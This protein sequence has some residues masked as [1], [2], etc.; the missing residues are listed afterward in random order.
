MSVIGSNILAGASG[1]GGF[2]I[3]ESLRFNASQSSYL[4]W[5]PAS[6]GNRKTWTFSAWVKRGQLG[7]TQQIFYAKDGT[8][9]VLIG[10]TTNNQLQIQLGTP[11]RRT[12]R[13]FRDPSAWYHIVGIC[14]TTNATGDDRLQ[15]WV[16]GERQTSFD[17]DTDPTLNSDSVVSNTVQ[18]NLGRGDATHYADGYLTEVN[19]IDGQALDPSSFGAF[20]SVTG[21]WKPVEY[22]GTYGTNGFYLP[23]QLDNTVEGFNTVTWVGNGSTQKI[24]GVGFSPDLV[25]IK[26]RSSADNHMIFDSVRGVYERL[27]SNTTN[28]EATNTTSFTSFDTD[29]F[30]LGTDTAVNA[31]SSTYVGWCWDAGSST[32][33]NTDGS[34]TSSVRANP[35]YGFSV[36]TYT[37]TGTST[38]DSFGHALGVQPKMVIIKNRTTGGTGWAVLFPD[39]MTSGQYMALNLTNGITN[40]ANAG[41]GGSLPDS[42]QVYVGGSSWTNASGNN[43]VA[44]CFSE[45]AGY[46]KF[47]SYA[48]TGASGN[49]VTTGFKPAFVLFK[50]TDTSGYSWYTFDSTRNAVNPVNT[51]LYP[52]LTNTDTTQSTYNIDFTDTGFTINNSNNALNASGGTYIYM[53]FKDTR[54]YAYWLDDSGNNNDWQPNGG[55]TTEST[56]TDTPTPYAD[57]GNYCTLNP[58]DTYPAMQSSVVNG[59]LELNANTASGG[60]GTSNGTI[61][62]NSGKWYFE[63]ELSGYSG[64]SPLRAGWNSVTGGVGAGAGITGA[65]KE[66][67]SNQTVIIAVDLDN[68]LAWV[69]SNGSWDAGNPSTGTG[70][71]SIDLL[72]Y[73]AVPFVRDNSGTA[74]NGGKWTVNF[75]QRPFAYTPPTGFLPLHTGNL[76]DSAIVDGSEYF[77]PVLYTGNNGSNRAITGVG[78]APDLVWLKCRS[79]AYNHRLVDKLQGVSST[80][81]SN[82]TS[83][84]VDA[85]SEFNSLDSD[86]FTITQGSSFEF[87]ANAQTYVAWNWKSNGAGVSNTD[88]SITSTV[89]ANP[90]AGFSIVTYTG[91]GSVATVGHGLGATPDVIISKSRDAGENWG[92]YHKSVGA[93]AVTLLNSTGVPITTASAYNNTNP[94]SAVFTV[95]SSGTTNNSGQDYVAYC[96]ADVEGYSKFGSYEGN[97]NSNG[98]FIYCGFRPAWL[99]VKNIDYGSTNSDWVIHD[100]KRNVYNVADHHLEANTSNAE[101]GDARP[102]DVDFLSNGF[103][104]RTDGSYYENNNTQTYIYMAF[105]E[106]PF[107]NS[108]AR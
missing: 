69:G 62:V 40:S 5:T 83:A 28:A 106:N 92:V 89:S 107:K 51:A 50:R 54:E 3:E 43:Y 1:Q 20:D 76:P 29:G 90:T 93:T 99:M 73:L 11:R 57:G 12:V 9:Y 100:S 87:N 22:T 52:D 78:F 6:A 21:V 44:Y 96:F 58:L 74:G 4:S 75:G 85:S 2:T 24:S 23:M 45:V 98:P 95:N 94:T 108:L 91:T 38:G 59:N 67:S 46:S 35:T 63:A 36:V 70:G 79:S 88:G 14:D 81:A 68:L 102:I 8:N 47:G 53:A 48:G 39:F 42:T 64:S 97:S 66:V 60:N 13:V 49:T 61:A 7:T 71:T 27:Q 16:N 84:A 18:H 10:F 104:I 77:N 86:G 25:W 19:F 33:S 31:N 80:L 34:I 82:L 30:A 55:I 37:G 103:K 101:D 72:G 41:W 32:V 15:L 105:A 17:E 56:V 26:E 65:Y